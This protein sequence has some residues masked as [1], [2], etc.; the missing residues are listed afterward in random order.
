MQKQTPAGSVWQ[1]LQPHLPFLAWIGSLRD[2]RVLRADLLAGLTGAIVV[3]PQGVAF[4]TLA[5]MPPQYG[6]YSAMVPC[7]VAALFGASRL[8]V[9]GPANAISL[10]V[11]SLIA[12]LAVAG[13]DDYVRLVLTLT[14]M[15]ACW[16][17]LIGWAGL[18]RLVDRVPHSVIVGF[19]AGA[20]VLI[21][22]SQVRNLFGFDWPRGL[23]VWQTL[24][25]FVDD[26]AGID[27]ATTLVSAVT[28]VACVL[29]KPWNGRVPYM[30]VG[31]LAGGLFAAAMPLFWNGFSVASVER[32]PGA[33]PP[34]STPD[35]SF[36]TLRLLLMPS[37][38]MTLLALAEAISIARAIA[39]KT[40][41]P[42]DGNREVI[43]QGLA[44]LAGSFFS[45]YPASGSFNRSGVNV[46]AG[47]RT[48]L[49]AV[50]AALFLVLLLAFVAPLSK[51]LPL[52]AVAGILLMVAIG[53]IDL[54]EIRHI[55][56][57]DRRDAVVMAV[58]FILVLAIPLEW[59]VLA[60]IG[61]HGI[62]GMLIDRQQKV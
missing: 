20:A 30:L 9:T 58:T 8:M 16:Q 23:S 7:I 38:V 36:D 27:W 61:V 41:T 59:A 49:S 21:V 42:L 17:L 28:V 48:P 44:N 60:G 10:T 29:A 19:T 37:L 13:S 55:A 57:H 35:L 11:L 24:Q 56:Q 2:R 32:L 15:V 3:L 52:A 34:L 25:R 47:A 18:G 33:L 26:A 6:L 39:V 4:A 12:P 51:W 43:G 50:S 62:L 46:A 31:V 14:F 1:R 5:G 54:R 53:L 45:S 40:G 22:N